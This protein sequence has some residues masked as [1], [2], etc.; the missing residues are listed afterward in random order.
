MGIKI[1]WILMVFKTLCVSLSKIWNMIRQ[2]CYLDHLLILTNSSFKDRLLKLEMV[3]TRLS[4]T[5]MRVNISKSK[6]FAVWDESEH[7]KI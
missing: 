2:A 4:T 1:S 6:F 7:L 3:L 5:S